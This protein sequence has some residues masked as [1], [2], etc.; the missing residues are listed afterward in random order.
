MPKCFETWTVLPHEP[1]EKLAP[2][3]WRV[4]GNLPRGDTRRVMTVAKMRDGGLVIHNAIALEPELM[5]ELEAFGEPRAL[6]VP[7]GYHRLD[8]KVFKERYPKAA[9]VCP[10]GARARVAQGVA[11]DHSYAD[12]PGDDDVTL[13]HLPGTADREGVLVVRSGGAA[14]LVFND[15]VNNLPKQ[16]G[17]FGFLFAPTGMA[18]V[19]RLARWMMV[20]DRLALAAELERLADTPGLARVIV[21]HGRMIDHDAAAALRAAGER[22]RA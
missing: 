7:G 22:L 4:E 19:P 6:V 18:A 9:V 3:L 14:T 13:A 5:A 15:V 1:I 21:S 17:L 2:N 20:K 10:A 11:P 16:G 12:A 8:A